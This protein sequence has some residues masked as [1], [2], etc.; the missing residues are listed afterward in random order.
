MVGLME[1]LTCQVNVVCAVASYWLVVT[2]LQ[3]VIA[4][5]TQQLVTSEKSW[6]FPK[7]RLWLKF[8]LGS[9]T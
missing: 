7:K 9:F 4:T 2:V 5:A 6:R 1:Y 8:R 3:L